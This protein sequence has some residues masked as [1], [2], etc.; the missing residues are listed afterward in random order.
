MISGLADKELGDYLVIDRK[1][2]KDDADIFLDNV[3][4]EEVKKALDIK[5][6]KS[7]SFGKDFIKAIISGK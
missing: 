6:V 3:T 5:M 1:M 2:L 7:G 4:L